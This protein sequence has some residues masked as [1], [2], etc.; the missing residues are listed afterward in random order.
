MF[1]D[2]NNDG[3]KLRYEAARDL[4]VLFTEALQPINSINTWVFGFQTSSC[5]LDEKLFKSAN[6]DPLQSITNA[7]SIFF[8]LDIVVITLF[9]NIF[10]LNFAEYKLSSSK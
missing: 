6:I 8:V 3:S 5:Y 1:A 7:I 4:A 2:L 9:I 10:L